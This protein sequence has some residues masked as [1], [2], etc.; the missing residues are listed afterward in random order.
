MKKM[1]WMIAMLLVG[2]LLLSGCSGGDTE[3]EAEAETKAE[4]QLAETA[5]E[6]AGEDGTE[7]ENTANKDHYV[8]GAI[9][10]GLASPYQQGHYEW[11][12]KM[13]EEKGWEVI[14]IDGQVDPETKMKGCETLISRGVDVI[15]VQAND[16]AG[17]DSLIKEAHSAGIPLVNFYMPSENETA[18]AVVIDE[19]ETS[20]ELGTIAAEKWQSWYPDQPIKVGILDLPTSSQVHEGRTMAFWDGVQSVAPD[21][22]LVS[23]L[24]GGSVR[25]L[26]FTAAQDLLQ[27]HPE[28]NIVY[29]I[30]SESALGAL[31]AFEEAGRGK[32]EDGVPL[33]ELFVGTNGS[34]VEAEKLYDPSSAFKL[35]QALQPKANAQAVL[36]T[37]EKIFNG[38]LQMTDDVVV[39]AYNV[40]FTYWDTPIEEYEQFM[41]DE[42]LSE[43]GFAERMAEYLE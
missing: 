9:S 24:D 15:T 2:V 43:P 20:F 18:P 41:V 22:E 31:A 7:A 40:V 25:D 21:A 35:T 5:A 13:A 26:S 33:T 11:L 4:T 12:E 39:D 42:Y 38:E 10:D 23:V 28:V 1:K 29:G 6:E 34:E 19:Y 32:A 17:A 36:D 27:S 3:T 8:I 14:L 16:T 30:N 37:I